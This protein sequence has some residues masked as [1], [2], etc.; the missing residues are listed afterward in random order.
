MKKKTTVLALNQDFPFWILSRSFGE[1]LEGKPGR[2][3]YVIR[4]H[5]DVE[6]TRREGNSSHWMFMLSC[7]VIVYSHA[8]IWRKEDAKPSQGVKVK[9]H[10]DSLL[11]KCSYSSQLDSLAVTTLPKYWSHCMGTIKIQSWVFMTP[12]SY[13]KYVF[14]FVMLQAISS[15]LMH[16]QSRLKQHVKGSPRRAGSIQSSELELV[17]KYM[18]FRSHHEK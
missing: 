15:C 11:T 8:M 18:G 17:F 10:V 12:M 2:I 3:F 7:G 1:K 6:Y 4:W 13:F 14:H 5:C 9:W 16:Y